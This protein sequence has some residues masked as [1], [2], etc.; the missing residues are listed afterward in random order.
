MADVLDDSTY[1]DHVEVLAA[2]Q[3]GHPPTVSKLC[4]CARQVGQA[5]AVDVADGHVHR[6]VPHEQRALAGEVA[7]AV[8]E[9]HDAAGG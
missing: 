7:C 3:E 1:L 5:V 2:G 6:P 8:V 4:S 9:E